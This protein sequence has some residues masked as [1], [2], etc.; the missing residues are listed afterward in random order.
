LRIEPDTEIVPDD[1]GRQTRAKS[2]RL[3]DEFLL[4]AI[5]SGLSKTWADVFPI[6]AMSPKLVWR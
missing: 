2:A 6:R 5:E 1:L 4:F 3:T